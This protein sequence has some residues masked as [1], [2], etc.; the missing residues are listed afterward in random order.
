MAPSRRKPE[1]RHFTQNWQTQKPNIARRSA[2]SLRT[3]PK[4]LISI[5]PGGSPVKWEKPGTPQPSKTSS[6]GRFEFLPEEQPLWIQ[7]PE[8]WQ[9]RLPSYHTIDIHEP[10]EEP[11]SDLLQCN[12]NNMPNNHSSEIISR[13]HDIPKTP[14]GH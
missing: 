12:D 1:K 11:N 9:I 3:P 13:I 10:H 6:P 2:E 4:S 7:T 8:N 5:T 14:E